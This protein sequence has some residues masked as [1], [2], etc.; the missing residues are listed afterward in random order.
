MAVWTRTR[1]RMMA[2]PGLVVAFAA[3]G[4]LLVLFVLYP[5]V[6]V[7]IYPRLAH[8]L[9]VPDT[10]RWL[11]AARNSLLM[12]VL[13]TLTATTVGFLYAFAISRRDMPLRR[14]FQTLSVLPLF[15]PPFMVAFSYILMFGRQGLIT[16]ALFGLDVN[17][18]GWHGLWLVQTVAFFPF[19]ALVIGAV[20]EQISPT[21]EYAAL[22]LGATEGGVIRTVLFPL[23]R[24]GVAAAALVVAISVLADFGNAVVI[25]GGFPLLATE[26][27][28]R[29]EGLADLKGAAVA[30]ALL[31]VPTM[32]L[33]L[34][35]RYWVGQR[36]YTVLTGKGTRIE[37][38]PTPPLIRWLLFGGCV[39][40]SAF[41]V[42]VYVGVLTGSVAT[43]WGYKWTPTLAHWRLGLA[44]GGPP[45]GLHRSGVSPR[46]Q[47]SPD[48]PV[49]DGVD[50]HPGALLLA[51]SARLPGRA[52]ATEADRPIHRRGGPEPG[53][54]G[55]AGPLGRLPA[56]VGARLHGV[57]YQ[58]LHPGR[59]QP[60]HR[61]LPDHA[62]HPGRHLLDPGHDRW[63]IL[64]GG[65]GTDDGA[66]GD[67]TVGRGRSAARPARRSA[68]DRSDLMPDQPHVR[69]I[70]V[71][72][73]LGTHLAVDGVS[74]D[75]AEGTF[76]TLLGPS[77]C[78]KTTTLRMI[79]GFY[80]PDRGEIRIRDRVIN[81]IPPHR[82][83]TAMVFQEYAL[84]PHMTVAENV[85]YGLRMRRV[86]RPEARRRV[87][88]VIELVGL[89]GQER[90]FPHQLSGGQ[91]QRVA[92]A[93]ALIVEPEVLL[94]DEPLSNLDAKLRVRVRTEIRELQQRLGKTTLYVTHDQEEALAIS[95]QIAVMHNGRIL[96][97]GTPA[98]IYFH[99]ANRFVSHF[100]VL[101]NFIEA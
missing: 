97:V 54:H 89:S 82:R 60:Q 57:V 25:A 86:P 85:G 91:Q 53:G 77:G 5:A 43:V 13:S 38:P 80:S 8:Y 64:G 27:W 98:E 44:Q 75:V 10:P 87:A 70:E 78:G 31:I 84:F 35:E 71:T 99:P 29:I 68:T 59:D 46:L 81:D 69:L 7:L 48:H 90:K 73:R 36:T 66:A 61:R 4:A 67:H 51:H 94:L 22:N 1:G 45:R 56:A 6:R 83:N 26:A 62:A 40:V 42:I 37:Q 16:K 20:L 58:R 50:P 21:V 39:V 17:I 55:D 11:Q 34:L 47:R 63:R 49:R 9:A 76:M 52:G 15:A 18:F 19:A 23:A 72:K 3:V 92:L 33:F 95:D 93:R 24:P 100:F 79:A 65:G 74:L 12:M 88:L 32:I 96:Q 14:L 28:F 30:V 101:A 2:D 41:V